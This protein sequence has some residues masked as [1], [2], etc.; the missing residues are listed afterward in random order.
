MSMRSRQLVAGAASL[1][2][3]VGLGAGAQAQQYRGD[4][5]T[6]LDRNAMVGSGGKNVRTR[7]IKD[8]IWFNNQIITGN[9]PAGRSFRGYVGYTAPSQFR[10][11][12]G[13]DQY[14]DFRRD[15]ASG[16]AVSTGV[17]TSDA[18]RYQ[19][20]L[21]TGQS[22]PTYLANAYFTPRTS[23]AATALGA[24]T[25][26]QAALRSTSDYLAS[27]PLRPSFIGSREDTEGR[28][29]TATASGLLGISW[30]RDFQAAPP[31]LTPTPAAPASG[32]ATG[33]GGLTM[34]EVKPPVT[35][36]APAAPEPP[37]GLNASGLE[38][39]GLGYRPAWDAARSAEQE[40]AG[41]MMSR[42]LDTGV[43]ASNVA[44]RSVAHTQML[45]A[46]RT[47]Y[48]HEA[49]E[50][51]GAAPAGADG[52]RPKT[53]FESQMERLKRVLGGQ[54]PIEP[55]RVR[56]PGDVSPMKPGEVPA[57]GD[58]NRPGAPGAEKPKDDANAK[59]KDAQVPPGLVNALKSMG[60]KDLGTFMPSAVSDPAAYQRHMEAAR[61]DLTAERFFD[62]EDQF[63]R[64]IAA[65]PNDPLAK[66]GRIHAQ[67]GAGMYLSASSNLRRLV[68]DH[69]EVVGV[70]FD[71]KL[72]P[73]A[74]RAKT[75]ATELRGLIDQGSTG[76]GLE[77]SLLLTY[78][79]RITDDPAMTHEGLDDMST[80]LPKGDEAEAAFY[81]LLKGVWDGPKPA[82]G[83]PEP[84]PAPAPT[85]GKP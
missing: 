66:A 67:L 40:G 75:I 22:A 77:A 79:G 46:L 48:T 55:P 36:G 5:G 70:R 61:R 57:P 80:R 85:P 64:A 39:R 14:Y 82:P 21:T 59:D 34:P 28:R 9:A 74:E 16:A 42:G 23:N 43:A 8:Q 18:L 53:S 13:S 45:D 6:L 52:T 26:A 32:A 49:A 69:P 2:A 7:D 83:A 1:A 4:G 76:M 54:S 27:R 51:D 31:P 3:V 81:Q 29:W 15:S 38:A 17:R 65:M 68:R 35:P 84:T 50:K 30:V 62:A 37:V 12:T 20:A 78:L 19:F 63:T 11:F 72:A 25:S 24:T 41:N 58:T 47:A 73:D 60:E 10:G 44:A 71:P 33:A 56:E